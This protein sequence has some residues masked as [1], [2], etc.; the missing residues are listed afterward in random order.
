ME[1]P[2]DEEHRGSN[3]TDRIA[4]EVR[5]DGRWPRDHEERDNGA[6]PCEDERCIERGTAI[7]DPFPKRP[8]HQAGHSDGERLKTDLGAVICRSWILFDDQ[9][10]GDVLVNAG[11]TEQSAKVLGE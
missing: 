9:C 10:A 4:L 2:T 6:Q 3:E 8:R 5:C 11:A 7:A 1:P